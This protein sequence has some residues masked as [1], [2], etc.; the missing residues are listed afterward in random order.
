MNLVLV[1]RFEVAVV[2]RPQDGVGD[3]FA[4]N[5]GDSL[6]DPLLDAGCCKAEKVLYVGFVLGV[7]VGFD[8]W[9]D[10]AG[11][12]ADEIGGLP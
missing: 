10:G 7:A 5:I 11:V 1:N 6:C 9:F 8:L 2:R 4:D 12:G 3:V